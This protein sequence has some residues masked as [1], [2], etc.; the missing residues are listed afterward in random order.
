[1]C[2]THARPDHAHNPIYGWRYLG[3][4]IFASNASR[5][6]RFSSSSRLRVSIFSFSKDFVSSARSL[7]STVTDILLKTW[8]GRYCTPNRHHHTAQQ[9]NYQEQSTTTQQ[10]CSMNKKSAQEQQQGATN[11]AT[12]RQPDD[13]RL[14]L[15]RFRGVTTTNCHG[16][17]YI[18]ARRVQGATNDLGKR[19]RR[20]QILGETEATRHLIRRESVKLGTASAKLRPPTVPPIP[21]G[22][23]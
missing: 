12:R 17:E 10:N 11:A 18:S 1:M 20:A 8:P 7:A 4:A 15:A 5:R 3:S 13:L 2:V 21:Y 22:Y 19:A 16:N 6:R 9:M 23:V 14:K